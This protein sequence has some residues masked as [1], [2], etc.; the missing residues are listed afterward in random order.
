[1]W[2]TSVLFIYIICLT[3]KSFTFANDATCR[4][5]V[6]G[7]GGSR[8]SFEAGVIARIAESEKNFD[9]IT[10]ISVGSIN[11]YYL[12]TADDLYTGSMQL[13]KLWALMKDSD[14][15]KLGPDHWWKMRSVLD[16]TPL[17]NTLMRNLI[18]SKLRRNISIGTTSL[19][20]GKL[21]IFREDFF[22][23]GNL[24]DI[25]DVL[26]ASSA[27]PIAFPPVKIYKK[28][29]WYVDGGTI[30]NTL[31]DYQRCK[32]IGK[33][34]NITIDIILCTPLVANLSTE[35]VEE[36]HLSQL[37][38]RNYDIFQNMAFNHPLYGTC[39][40][41]PKAASS[42]IDTAHAPNITIR[43]HQ[44]FSPLNVSML[45]FSHGEELWQIGY[46]HSRTSEYNYC[47]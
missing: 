5:L 17:R 21:E 42:R 47:I 23:S 28:A 15:Y 8:G 44:P 2:K 36:Y 14:V 18:G 7:G 41:G 30:G 39:G 31:L 46:L 16:S 11:A 12:S 20:S 10:G 37:F 33:Y 34:E 35:V 45:D 25:V 19:S 24:S 9:L 26:M 1:M 4:I 29:E 22:N 27:I 32:D 13:H 38:W 40:D 3:F 43:L 6:F